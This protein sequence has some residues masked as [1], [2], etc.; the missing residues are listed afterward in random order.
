MDNLSNYTLTELLKLGKDVV[1][2][3]DEL[4]KESLILIDNL[5]KIEDEI[6]TNINNITIYEKLYVDIV[7]EFDKR[8]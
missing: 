5:K 1:K 2:K 6:N 7:K 3:H 8:K 4:K